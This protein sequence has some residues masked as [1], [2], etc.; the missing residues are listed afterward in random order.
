MEEKLIKAAL[1]KAGLPEGFL[2]FITATT[3]EE[4]TAQVAELTG[5]IPAKPKTLAEVLADAEIKKAYDLELQKEGDRRVSQAKPK[6]EQKA[7]HPDDDAETAKIR[8]IVG[9]MF[10]ELKTIITEQ[11]KQATTINRKNQ[12]VELLKTAGIP[13]KAIELVNLENEDIAGQV[14]KL[15]EVMGIVTQQG[16]D[17]QLADGTIIPKRGA[18]GELNISESV[19]KDVAT[20]RNNE[21]AG[22][23]FQT[24][25]GF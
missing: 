4:L 21:A 16:A 17:Q 11:Q 20:A 18:A 24:P 14:G 10:D 15:K 9:P 12:A 25:K 6:I 7:A 22:G 5:L 8:T 23:G 1:Q 2:K 19:I 3:A 13:E